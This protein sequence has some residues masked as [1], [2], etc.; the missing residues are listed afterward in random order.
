MPGWLPP[1]EYDG[2]CTNYDQTLGP[3][4]V[5]QKAPVFWFPHRL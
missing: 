5:G 4:K 2:G 1:A 3:A